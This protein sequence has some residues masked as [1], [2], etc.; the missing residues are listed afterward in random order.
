MLKE[1]YWI[2]PERLYYT[3]DPIEKPKIKPEPIGSP[4]IV[5][6]SKISNLEKFLEQNMPYNA[7]A[8]C[9]SENFEEDQ[10]AIQYFKI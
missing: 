5:N 3:T 10:I 8:F 6:E 7:N 4:I 2:S 9:R 1:I